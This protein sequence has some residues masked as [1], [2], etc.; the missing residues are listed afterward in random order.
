M[1]LAQ[2]VSLAT[3]APCTEYAFPVMDIEAPM[4]IGCSAALSDDNPRAPR[5]PERKP[6]ALIFKCP[7]SLV[8]LSRM[9]NQLMGI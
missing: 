1:L 8:G 3:I 2:L 6:N 7:L 4:R 9:T 5:S